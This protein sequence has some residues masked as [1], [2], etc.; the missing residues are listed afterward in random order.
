MLKHSWVNKNKKYAFSGISKIYEHYK[1][2]LPLNE[3]QSQL[4]E[5]QTYTRHK[6]GK[7]TSKFNPF[8]VHK[9]DEMWQLDIMYLPNYKKEAQGYKYLL[10]VLDVF[11][12]KMFIRK[13]RKKDTETVVR[14]FDQI[15]LDVNRS[16]EKIV[17]DK[18]SEFKSELF[19]RYC[20]GIG[21]KLIFTYN[22]TKAAHVERAQRS[23]QNILYRILEEHQTRDFLK[24]LKDTLNIYNNRVNRTTGYSPNFAYQP[25]NHEKISINLE[26]HYN[27]VNKTRKKPRF[28]KGDHVRIRE[29]KQAFSRG[30]HPYFTEEIFKVE[31]VLTNLP[32]PR[33]VLSNYSGEEEIKGSFYGNELALVNQ[34][35]FKV[36][37]ILKRKKVKGKTLLF[38]KWL[39]Y[40]T[41]ENSWIESS[42]I[43]KIK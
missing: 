11:S 36:E 34:E 41:S 39:G 42:W 32:I 5:I 4:S 16:P 29:V 24:Y 25:E 21:I 23:F 9:V 26:K 35:T 20:E 31:K 19:Q 8:F 18:G 3:I 43:K 13:L 33:Y 7:K 14:K 30:Y 40:P 6:E 28:K 10:C 17:V 38:V 15:L 12:R 27:T 1:G 22:D 37:K 2:A